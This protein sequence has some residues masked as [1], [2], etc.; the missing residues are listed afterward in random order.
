MPTADRR[1][2]LLVRSAC[3]LALAAGLS[4]G[5][6]APEASVSADADAAAKAELVVERDGTLRFV[7]VGWDTADPN[8]HAD[9]MR[10]LQ[11]WY[12]DREAGTLRIASQDGTPWSDVQRLLDVLQEAGVEDYRIDLNVV[13]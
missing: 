8:Q 6:V 1:A 7:G 9:L 13:D 4:Q 5:C 10:L 2:P 11:R 12:A 3:A